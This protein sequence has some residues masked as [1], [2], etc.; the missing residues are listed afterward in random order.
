MDTTTVRLL[1]A[2]KG[3]KGIQSD[4]EVAVRLGVVKQAVSKWR[5]GTAHA[6]P[7]LAAEMA[8][9]IGMDV[10]GVLASIEADRALDTAT[11]RLWARFGKGAFMALLVGLAVAAP[12]PA[13][14]LAPASS[15]ADVTGHYAKWRRRRLRALNRESERHRRGHPATPC[16][17]F[18]TYRRGDG[19]QGRRDRREGRRQAG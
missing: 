18:L 3:Q 9:Q 2:Y 11:R 12:A 5:R 10:L 1:D 7:V 19:L 4:S 16:T 17:S 13:P 14:A 15:V 6:S 8:E